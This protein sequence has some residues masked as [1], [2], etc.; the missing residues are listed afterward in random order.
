[1]HRFSYSRLAPHSNDR[2]RTHRPVPATCDRSEPLARKQH[3][4][5]CS[6]YRRVRCS[7]QPPP[8]R[9][10]APRASLSLEPSDERQKRHFEHRRVCHV[11]SVPKCLRERDLVLL[12]QRLL[13]ADAPRGSLS[14]TLRSRIT[15]RLP[16]SRSRVGGVVCASGLPGLGAAGSPA[17]APGTPPA[18]QS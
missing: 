4:T 17:G 5:R 2:P 18:I 16:A 9:R 12:F 15:P 3:A 14:C 10:P 1:M 8:P 11:P 7:T 13:S 6:S